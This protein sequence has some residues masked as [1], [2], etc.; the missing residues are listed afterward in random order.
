MRSRTED[1]QAAPAVFEQLVTAAAAAAV[2]E[3]RPV[4]STLMSVSV[5][6]EQ[7]VDHR[8]AHRERLRGAIGLVLPDP[9]AETPASAWPVNAPGASVSA[10]RRPVPR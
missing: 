9:D 4:V 7:Q 3:P 1:D 10:S 8:D 2:A 6:L 5:G